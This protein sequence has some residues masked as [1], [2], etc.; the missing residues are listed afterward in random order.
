MLIAPLP[1]AD[2][3]LGALLPQPTSHAQI[4]NEETPQSALPGALIFEKKVIWTLG[5]RAER[6]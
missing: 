1:P 6:D 4:Q 5:I 3:E 2:S